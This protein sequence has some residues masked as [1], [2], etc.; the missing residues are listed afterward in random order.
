MIFA[1]VGT[2]LPFDRLIKALDE[3]APLIDEE[4]VAQV[5]TKSVYA[6][7]HVRALATLDP[8]TFA[9]TVSASR[10]IVAHAGIGTILNARKWGKP[11]I[12]VP[13]RAGL[14]EHRNDHQLATCRQLGDRPGIH[15]A[16]T[17]AELAAL[18][19]RRDLCGPP[20]ED[21]AR[22]SSDLAEQLKAL[23]STL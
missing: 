15:V 12:I 20:T 9:S 21:A 1:T 8:M 3:V 7:K 13:R 23:I 4:I 11:L 5:G 22:K 14:G 19:Q 6:P 2:Q 16:E 17:E 18:I 10:L